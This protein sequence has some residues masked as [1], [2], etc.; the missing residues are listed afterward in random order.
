MSRLLQHSQEHDCG[1]ITAFRINDAEGNP[2]SYKEKQQRNKSLGAKLLSR[3]Y[4]VTAVRGKY[5]EDGESDPSYEDSYFVVDIK[6]KHKLE[7]TLIELGEYFEQDS[8][9]F[10]PKGGK[11]YLVGTNENGE[12]LEYGKKLFFDKT[13]YGEEGNP[14]TT[15]INDRPFY[16]ESVET[17]KKPP[18]T[19][20]GFWYLHVIANKDWRDVE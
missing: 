4:S 11:P 15:F 5:Q 3:G 18:N 12:W 14:F 8:I 13:K 19:G 10:I 1:G 6:D 20:Y 7:K 17:E 16:M 2:Y 9:L